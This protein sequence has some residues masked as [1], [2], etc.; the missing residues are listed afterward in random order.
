MLYDELRA[1]AVCIQAMLF[2]H[3]HLSKAA[4]VDECINTMRTWT[5][6]QDLMKFLKTFQ[7]STGRGVKHLTAMTDTLACAGIFAPGAEM[8]GLPGVH[9]ALKEGEQG[10]APLKS[11]KVLC[12]EFLKIRQAAR[13][14][15]S[16]RSAA[17]I[18]H[19]KDAS[20]VQGFEKDI[21][22]LKVTMP[23]AIREKLAELKNNS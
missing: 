13:W 10:E 3:D 21:K 11:Y 19:S 12:E 17:I 9:V 7:G 1:D 23:K 4:N 16:L 20:S 18:I 22:P 6:K 15:L 5:G 14:Q 8:N 2:D